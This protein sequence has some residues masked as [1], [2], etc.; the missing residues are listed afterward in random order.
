MKPI[1]K[2]VGGKT[3]LLDDI[4][5]LFPR[6]INNYYEPFLGG[7]SILFG[8]LEKIDRN[9]IVVSGRINVSDKNSV[10][11]HMFINIQNSH[12]E[13]MEYLNNFLNKYTHC[14]HD[15]GTRYPI[16]EDDAMLSRESYYYWLRKE[17]NEMSLDEKHS[18]Y[19]SAL[20]IFINKTCFRGL[21]RIGPNGLNVPFGNYH[22]F[23]NIISIQDL[24][25]MHRKIQNVVFRVSDFETAI[26]IIIPNDFVYF[27]P[28]YVPINKKSFVS[29]HSG[30]FTDE[31]HGKLFE[32]IKEYDARGLKFILSNSNT[33]FVR[34]SFRNYNTLEIQ[35]RRSINSKNPESTTEELMI[36][37]F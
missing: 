24:E 3:Q 15:N 34:D 28:P 32:K 19:G 31:D 13:L 26:D 16:N 5:A 33:K 4:L 8:L 12:L 35:A 22:K 37:N 27:D 2:W 21:Y 23:K 30:G 20:F 17:Y 1:I 18:T 6:E 11:I 29:Y 7:G 14:E 9:E 36:K 10:L 25:E